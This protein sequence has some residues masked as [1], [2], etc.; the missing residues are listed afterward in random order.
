MPWYVEIVHLFLYVVQQ[1]KSAW[2][3]DRGPRPR[4]LGPV[5]ASPVCLVAGPL[6]FLPGAIT[7]PSASHSFPRTCLPLGFLAETLCSR[8]GTRLQ[9][10]LAPDCLA[11]QRDTGEWGLDNAFWV[12]P[13][14]IPTYDVVE[15]KQ[16]LPFQQAPSRGQRDL[17]ATEQSPKVVMCLVQWAAE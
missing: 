4:L 9:T 12:I 6:T 15:A 17:G 13:P 7:C 10:W 16:R 8:L 5:T 14:L 2:P 1:S 3:S 11:G